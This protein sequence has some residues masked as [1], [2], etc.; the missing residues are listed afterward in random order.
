MIQKWNVRATGAADGL[1][2]PI[3]GPIADQADENG[4]WSLWT[5]DQFTIRLLQ[6]G[7]IVCVAPDEA[8]K[9]PEGQKAAKETTK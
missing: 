5:P 4:I 7:A 2:H 9:K 6:D 8:P 1:I 3:D